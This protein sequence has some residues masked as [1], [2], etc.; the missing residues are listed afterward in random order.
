MKETP[1]AGVP[2]KPIGDVPAAT[3][4]PDRLLHDAEV[5]AI[6]GRSYPGYLTAEVSENA[7]ILFLGHLPAA[8]GPLP[9]PPVACSG[10]RCCFRQV[11]HTPHLESVLPLCPLRGLC[12]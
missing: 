5:I 9:K 10:L 8:S 2:G 4:I 7:E 1:P 6:P 12:G 11:V 3:A